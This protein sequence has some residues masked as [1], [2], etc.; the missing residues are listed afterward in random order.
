[1]NR[2]LKY[3]TKYFSCPPRFLMEWLCI[4]LYSC[5]TSV[6]HRWNRSESSDR[7]ESA[8]AGRAIE[9]A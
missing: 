6:T 8:I 1:M 2:R 4:K 7:S 5:T 3:R 9:I